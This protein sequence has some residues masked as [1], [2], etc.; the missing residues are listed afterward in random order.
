[1]DTK[2]FNDN[3]V[4]LP[5]AY[6][7]LYG[8]DGIVPMQDFEPLDR[9]D[10]DEL[11]ALAGDLQAQFNVIRDLASDPVFGDEVDFVQLISKDTYMS[12]LEGTG[13]EN[14]DGGN[15]EWNGVVVA[16]YDGYAPQHNCVGIEI[17][18]IIERVEKPIENILVWEND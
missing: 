13:C 15:S 11:D 6:R 5:I 3:Y 18:G 1:M 2:A 10:R 7:E 14:T 8:D 12:N 17:A 9:S 16:A 4:F